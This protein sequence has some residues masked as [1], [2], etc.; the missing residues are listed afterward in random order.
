M[1]LSLQKEL[2]QQYLGQLRK[3]EGRLRSMHTAQAG[4]LVENLGQLVSPCIL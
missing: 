1:G 4:D 3:A 2:S